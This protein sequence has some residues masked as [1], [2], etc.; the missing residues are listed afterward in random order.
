MIFFDEVVLDPGASRNTNYSERASLRY[1]AD[2]TTHLLARSLCD[3][4]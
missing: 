4:A 1:E 3:L 2:E